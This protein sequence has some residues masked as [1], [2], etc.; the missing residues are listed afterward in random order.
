MALAPPQHAAT[1][2]YNGIC[3]ARVHCAGLTHAHAHVLHRH[4]TATNPH[5]TTCPVQRTA[6]ARPAGKSRSTVS[7]EGV[8][9]VAGSAAAAAPVRAAAVPTPVRARRNICG[10]RAPCRRKIEIAPPRGDTLATV[11]RPTVTRASHIHV[12]EGILLRCRHGRGRGWRGA[13]QANHL[14][15]APHPWSHTSPTSCTTWA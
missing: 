2:R 9:S 15:L 4:G 3:I 12:V 11:H 1:V 10:Q 5:C 13:A 7:P 6:P 8:C 14:L